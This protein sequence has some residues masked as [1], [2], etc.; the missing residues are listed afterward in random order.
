MSKLNYQK[1]IIGGTLGSDAKVNNFAN[2]GGVMTLNVATSENWKKDDEW[3]SKTTWHTVK[4]FGKS[5]EYLSPKCVKGV[6]VMVEGI[7]NTDEYEK[8]GVKKF[9]TF[10]KAVNV[11]VVSGQQDGAQGQLQANSINTND[12]PF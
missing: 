3:Q 4:L 12:L 2:G 10:I 11:K 1:I 6:S 9:S 5:V 8:D 7:L